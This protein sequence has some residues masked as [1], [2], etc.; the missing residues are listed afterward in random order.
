[1]RVEGEKAL[2]PSQTS[3]IDEIFFESSGRGPSPEPDRET[4]RERRLG[5]F[6]H[7][8]DIVLLAADV[9]ENVIGYL[10]G[11]LRNPAEQDRFA[12]ISY[13][14]AEFSTLCRQY[15]AHLHINLSPAHRGQGLGSRL[16]E[17][18]AGIARDAGAPGLHVVT[19][20]ELRNVRFYLR[21]GFVPRG[22]AP[23]NGGEI[24]FLGRRLV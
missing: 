12:D 20:K 24:V 4:F 3:Q 15:P 5:R 14:R 1:V 13:F 11:A 9:D 16:I 21:C 17:T 22:Y 8:N 7:G 10:V 18:F 19:G 2:L 6:L 23:R